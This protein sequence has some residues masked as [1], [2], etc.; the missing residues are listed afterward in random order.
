MITGEARGWGGSQLSFL[1]PCGKPIEMKALGRCRRCYDRRQHSLRFFGGLREWVLA[2]DR[3]RCRGCGARSRLVVHHRDGRN[4]EDL[5]ITLCA[6]CHM[7][8]HRSSGVRHWLSRT[9][10]G[11]WRELHPH[12]PAQL[13]LAFKI[14]GQ[15]GLDGAASGRW[16]WRKGGKFDEESDDAPN[17]NPTTDLDFSPP[18]ARDLR[19]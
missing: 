8:T 4:R 11:L 7:R 1:C 9:L 10:L 15:S 14:H 18:A 2:R 6:R 13:Q 17:R 19:E 12:E 16:N 5:L 3:F